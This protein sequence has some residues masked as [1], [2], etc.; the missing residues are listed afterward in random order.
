VAG[1]EQVD[2][3]VAV[4]HLHDGETPPEMPA[5]FQFPSV[6]VAW[7]AQPCSLDAAGDLNGAGKATAAFQS[8]W[9]C[10]RRGGEM[11]AN[12][13]RRDLVAMAGVRT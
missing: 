13:R 8:A 10:P 9:F 11:M 12:V 2:D 7:R 3:A 4:F 6:D 5:A 1:C